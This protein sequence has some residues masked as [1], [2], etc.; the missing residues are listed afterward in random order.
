MGSF[1]RVYISV[2][3]NLLYLKPEHFW[4]PSIEAQSQMSG[5]VHV[6]LLILNETLVL[7]NMLSRSLLP[8]WSV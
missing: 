7:R 2:D 8:D 5:F 6:C 1:I 3:L 4:D